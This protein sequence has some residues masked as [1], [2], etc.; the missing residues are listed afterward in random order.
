MSKVKASYGNRPLRPCKPRC[1]GFPWRIWSPA[2]DSRYTK[3]DMENGHRNS[4]FTHEK[5]WIFPW[6]R[7]FTRGYMAWESIILVIFWLKQCHK[8]THHPQGNITILMYWQYKPSNMGWLITVYGF[9]FLFANIMPYT[10]HNK[11]MIQWMV[12]NPWYINGC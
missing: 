12:D 4:G 10:G 2:G 1:W 11:N 9:L 5:W 6:L 7:W 8:R 3:S